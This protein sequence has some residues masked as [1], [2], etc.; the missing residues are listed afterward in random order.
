VFVCVCVPGVCVN[1]QVCGVYLCVS[2]ILNLN[3]R[4][5]LISTV[6]SCAENTAD[7]FEL[8][9]LNSELL[10]VSELSEYA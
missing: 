4:S 10:D 7:S 3:L 5:I 1:L 9:K 6:A 8:P 2:L